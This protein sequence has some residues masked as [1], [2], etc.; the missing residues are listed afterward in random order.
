[1]YARTHARAR[2]RTHA[3]MHALYLLSQNT[4]II[5]RCPPCVS[6]RSKRSILQMLPRTCLRKCNRFAC[7]PCCVLHL[8]VGIAKAAFLRSGGV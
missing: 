4:S 8:L 2:A 5:T 3:R 7:R 1:M 6:I